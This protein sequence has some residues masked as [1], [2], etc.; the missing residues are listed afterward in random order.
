MR[1]LGI[2]VLGVGEMGRR[3]AENLRRL[4]PE[5]NLVAVADVAADRARQVAEEL[6]IEKLGSDA[7][8][9]ES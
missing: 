3:H 5:A 4:V 8:V 2:G 9:Q 7:R 6:E 1:K